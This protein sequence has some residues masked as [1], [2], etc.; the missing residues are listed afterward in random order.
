MLS[1]KIKNLNRIIK[2]IEFLQDQA[3]EVGN[4][5]LKNEWT[6]ILQPFYKNVRWNYQPNPKEL[7][8]IMVKANS[9]W[10]LLRKELEELDKL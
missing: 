8:S 1:N 9:D 3:R 4:I 10:K 5:D 7:R 2:K 6:E